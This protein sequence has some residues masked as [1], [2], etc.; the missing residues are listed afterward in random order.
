MDLVQTIAHEFGH[1]LGLDHPDEN[2][3]CDTIDEAVMAPTCNSNARLRQRQLYHYDT[4]CIQALEDDGGSAAV[5]TRDVE[6]RVFIQSSNGSFSDWEQSPES[7]IKGSTMRT[8]SSY[9]NQRYRA[10]M[11]VLPTGENSHYRVYQGF[12]GGSNGEGWNTPGMGIV[13]TLSFWTASGFDDYVRA[14]RQTSNDD[15]WDSVMRAAQARYDINDF[16]NSRYFDGDVTVCMDASCSSEGFV[17]SGFRLSHA[18]DDRWGEN[19]TA[20][21]NQNRADDSEDHEIWIASLVEDQTTYGHVEK[22]GYKTLYNPSVACSQGNIQALDGN[23]DCILAYT[24]FG[25]EIPR[26]ELRFFMRADWFGTLIYNWSEDEVSTY[27]TGGAPAVWYNNDEG[28]WYLARVTAASAGVRIYKSFNGV[29]WT[30]QESL[31]YSITSPVS[32]NVFSEQ[33]AGVVLTRP[34]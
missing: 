32:G 29:N 33:E 26:I 19:L 2:Q 25:T 5:G 30:F 12:Y 23:Y 20:Y 4:H 1:L 3:L 8:P 22:T 7:W 27:T 16:P 15:G 14:F 9:S 13:H 28:A 11:R 17:A 21:Q 34:Y 31:G 18:Q 6:S 24:S 10:M